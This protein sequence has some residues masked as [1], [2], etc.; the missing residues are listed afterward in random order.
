[1]I[2]KVFDSDNDKIKTE[3][4]ARKVDTPQQANLTRDKRL[5]NVAGAFVVLD[6]DFIK[7]KRVLLV[8]DIYTTGATLDECAKVLINAGAKEVRSMTLAHSHRDYPLGYEEKDDFEE[9]AG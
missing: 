4:L 6:Q 8:D 3:I 1:M 9:Y 2:L 7:D 5:E